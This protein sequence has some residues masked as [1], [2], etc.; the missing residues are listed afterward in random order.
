MKKCNLITA[1]SII[2]AGVTI[3]SIGLFMFLV[4]WA[5]EWATK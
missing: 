2:G 5:V 3:G 4:K 1:V